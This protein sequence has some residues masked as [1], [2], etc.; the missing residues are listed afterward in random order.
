MLMHVEVVQ[1]MPWLLQVRQWAQ[2]P[3][4]VAYTL[5][6]AQV[7]PAATG[8]RMTVQGAVR[9]IYTTSGRGLTLVPA[10]SFAT[11]VA[12]LFCYRY[13][14]ASPPDNLLSEGGAL[15]W[16]TAESATVGREHWDVS[17]WQRSLLKWPAAVL[18][19]E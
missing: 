14:S 6:A 13:P 18:Q 9:D 15:A 16:L 3:G 10:A 17:N 7:Q 12:M 8:A 11:L 5:P 19:G 2:K 1:F 4:F